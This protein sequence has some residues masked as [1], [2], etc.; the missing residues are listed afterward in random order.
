VLESQRASGGFDGAKLKIE[1]LK[2]HFPIERP[3][4]DVVRGAPVKVVRAV[5]DVTLGIR[6]SEVLGLV[7][8]TGC[9]KSTIAKTLLFMNPVT[10]GDIFFDGRSILGLSKEE[11][12]DYFSKVQM[13]W[14]DPFS[15]LN[16]RMKVYDTLSRPLVNFKGLGRSEIRKKIY[17]LIRIVGLNENELGHYPHE[18][19]G[20]G[21]QRIVIA[22]ALI[23]DPSFLIADEPTSSLDVS[24]QAQIL[25]LLRKLKDSY[26]LT[27]L[28]ISHDLAVINFISNR[29]AVMYFGRIVELM[30]KENLLRRNYHWYTNALIGAIPRG[31]R[32]VIAAFTEERSYRLNYNGCIYYHRCENAKDRCLN[33]VPVM[34][35]MEQ[36]HF[37]ACHYPRG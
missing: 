3:L 31:R 37:A 35:K 1:R 30:P 14:Q 32:R 36:N 23:S 26:N 24:I 20:G 16:P 11:L 25:N 27:M 7:G 33:V 6:E 10:G 17:D 9:G 5:D 19:S 34:E 18:F 15:C 13:V 8:E 2:V 29:V 12:A 21:R 4:L 22:R 28:F